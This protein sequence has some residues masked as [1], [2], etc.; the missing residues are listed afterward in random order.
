MD[1]PFAGI[2]VAACLHVT[3]ETA[4]LVGALRAGGARVFLTP[5]GVEIVEQTR[6]HAAIGAR[7]P[8]Y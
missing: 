7:Q 6:R 5:Y 3:A 2:T 8:I 1:K 4:G